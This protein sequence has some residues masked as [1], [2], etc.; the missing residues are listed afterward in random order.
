MSVSALKHFMVSLLIAASLTIPW[1]V[2]RASRI[3][4]AEKND[5]VRR[6]AARSAELKTETGKLSNQVAQAKPY[7]ALSPQELQELLRLRGEIARLRTQAP[8]SEEPPSTE[9]EEEIAADTVE[10]MKHVCL[11]LPGAM[12][13]FAYSHTNQPPRDFWDLQPF[14]PLSG[15]AKMAGLYTFEFVRDDG[16]Q[17]GDLLILREQQSRLRSDYRRARV[18]G[19]R[20]GSAIEVKM[21]RDDFVPWEKEH[22]ESPPSGD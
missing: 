15:G 12:Q 20:D 19:F 21:F 16:P 3:E 2:L 11:E 8:I 6:Q 4:L 13:R 14:F 7:R 22:M 10:A 17:P 1:L 9:P 18:Y 5:A